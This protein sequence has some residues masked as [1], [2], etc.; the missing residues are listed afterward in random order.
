M[1]GDCAERITSGGASL[2]V[3]TPGLPACCAKIGAVTPVVSI[4]VVIPTRDTQ[5]LTMRCLASVMETDLARTGSLRCIVV[6]NASSDGTG[7]VIGKRWPDVELVRSDVNLGFG[8]ACNEGAQRG[9]SELLLMLNSDIVA[10]TGALERLVDY[11]VRHDR[12]VA[13]TGRLVDYG[14]DRTQVGFVI[15]AFPRLSSQLALLVGLERF[16]PTNPISRRQL[17]LDFDY[18]ETQDVEAQ[19]A[20]ACL[21]CRRRDFDAIGGF[22][23]SFYYWFEDVDLVRRLRARGR[24]AYVHD[25]VFEHVGGNTFAQWNRSEIVVTRYR[26][27][28][29]YFAKHH[30]RRELLVLRVVVAALGVVRLVPMWLIDRDRA[31]AYLAVLSLAARTPA[32]LN[33]RD[34]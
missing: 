26:S 27:L 28:L 6:D 3:R 16:W 21:L 1:I 23:E 9:N 15:R 33:R 18:D 4:D 29:R 22:D 19:P 24:I 32:A 8:E 30:S 17:M 2:A 13:A 12:H 5:A 11:L 7:A 31:R 10:R 20:G 34:G 25:A 14:T